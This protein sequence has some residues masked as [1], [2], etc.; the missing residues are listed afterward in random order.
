MIGPTAK[1]LIAWVP[2]CDNGQHLHHPGLTCDEADQQITADQVWLART[3][4]TPMA[5][6]PPA[7]RGPNWKADR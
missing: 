4:G 5:D 6:V 2:G 7:L 3:I 1:K